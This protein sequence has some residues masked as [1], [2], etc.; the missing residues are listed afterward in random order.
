MA[1]LRFPPIGSP[2][3]RPGV[4][5]PC[6]RTDAEGRIP[7]TRDWRK[8]FQTLG[9]LGTVAV[10]SHHAYARLIALDGP[11]VLR[12]E[13]D[14]LRATSDS[15]ALRLRC[16]GWGG[17]FGRLA[18]CPCCDSPGLIEIQNAQDA[19]FLQL[20]ALPGSDPAAWARC[21][22]DAAGEAG[23]RHPVAP[24]VL[25]GISL[26]PEGIRRVAATGAGLPAFFS[27]VAAEAIRIRVLL[28]TPE[29][30]HLREFTPEYVTVSDPILT[31][32][33]RRVTLQLGLPHV[34][35]LNVADDGTLH[36]VGPTGA[37]L[38]SFASAPDRR[39]R[40]RVLLQAHF[41]TT[42]FN[43]RAP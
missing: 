10:Q 34:R 31:V 20:C 38:L 22:A 41:P 15:G 32:H 4:H 29:L 24:R 35:A 42:R 30:T 37:L 36:I 6:F 28:P 9:R 26:L 12:W 2:R 33:D 14:G 8:L 27:E 5:S 43:S 21:L 1:F 13:A 7:L 17:A 18:I 25:F 16:S 40:W 39:A 19:D 23:T 11:P 3:S